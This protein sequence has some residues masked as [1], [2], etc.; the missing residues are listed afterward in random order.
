MPPPF[1]MLILI[2]QKKSGCCLLMQN[3]YTEYTVSKLEGGE[4]RREDTQ[5]SAVNFKAS[6]RLLQSKLR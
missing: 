4:G 2:R 5:K 6:A 1:E 3:S